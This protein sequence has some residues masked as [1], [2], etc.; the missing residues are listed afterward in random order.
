MSL[1]VLYTP[2]DSVAQLTKH[3]YGGLREITNLVPRTG[4]SSSF[5]G[6]YAYNS[7]GKEKN[8]YLDQKGQYH[9]MSSEFI[10]FLF[11]ELVLETMALTLG[12]Q[13]K[14]IPIYILNT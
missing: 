3:I 7:S 11:F 14:R 2:I 13:N 4:Q 8:I 1:Y 10:S 12:K 9:F 6:I 5:L